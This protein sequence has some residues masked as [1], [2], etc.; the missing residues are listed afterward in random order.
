MRTRRAPGPPGFCLSADISI[1]SGG[2]GVEDCN[3]SV[4]CEAAPWMR[5]GLLVV[6]LGACAASAATLTKR[7]R[8]PGCVSKPVYVT[9]EMYKCA[10]QSGASSYFNVP[11]A[12]RRRPAGA[13]RHASDPLVEGGHARRA[14]RASIRT[15]RRDATTSAGRCCRTSSPQRRSSSPK[16]G[17]LYADGAPAP[18]PEERTDAEKYRVR[19]A[20]LRQTVNVHEKNIEA[21]RKELAAIK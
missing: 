1:H 12:R 16:R 2:C 11:G 4:R 6:L 15:R 19:I 8:N 18:L 9:G 3:V 10:T 13:A 14:S 7:R 20:R 21:L 17:S 5:V